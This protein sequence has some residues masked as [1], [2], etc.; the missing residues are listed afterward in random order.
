MP[1]PP[2]MSTVTIK[3][4]YTNYD[5][6]PV[7]GSVTFRT[8]QVVISASANEMILPTT[9]E[10]QLDVNGDF[11][12]VLPATDDVDYSPAN[13]VYRVTENFV[14][15]RSFVMS[16][17]AIIT[18]LLSNFGA[19]VDTAGWDVS[20][21]TL[22][23]TTVAGEF[24]SGVAGFK[25]VVTAT[26]VAAYMHNNNTTKSPVVPGTAY[27]V[28]CYAKKVGT[29]RNLDVQIVWLNSTGGEISSVVSSAVLVTSA[30]FVETKLENIDAPIGATHAYIRPVVEAADAV[31]SEVWFIDDLS[32]YKSPVIDLADKG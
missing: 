11:S 26:G 1:L 23:R 3:G 25:Y 18:N 31:A 4:S 6:T 2:S 15:G 16:A 20:N 17:P 9:V 30:G 32:F 8:D 27:S 21:I 29:S 13:F 19:E 7:I 14:G 22:S 5:G 24:R 12:V 10:V 28:S